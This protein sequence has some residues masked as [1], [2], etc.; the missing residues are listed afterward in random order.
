MAVDRPVNV[1]H[2]INGSFGE[3]YDEDGDFLGNVQGIQFQLVNHRRE[4]KPIGTSKVLSKHSGTEG[5]GTI[6]QFKMTSKMLVKIGAKIW[7]H[8]EPFNFGRLVVQ[9]DDPEAIGIEQLVL[10]GVRMWTLNGGW[11]TN[12]LVQEII[13][14]TFTSIQLPVQIPWQN[15]E[16][17]DDFYAARH[18][19]QRNL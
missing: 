8:L 14:F 4:W 2:I 10:N 17:F 16:M 9:L 12:Q 13:E 18:A 11:Q 3:L 7:D 6:E 19:A 5:R 15:R 1:N